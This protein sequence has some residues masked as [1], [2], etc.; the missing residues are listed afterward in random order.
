MKRFKLLT[1][2]S[3]DSKLLQL[4]QCSKCGEAVST[5]KETEILYTEK[6]R[7]LQPKKVAVPAK[8]YTS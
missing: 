2:G 8:P 7:A 4:A 6:P 1:V 3:A 5:D